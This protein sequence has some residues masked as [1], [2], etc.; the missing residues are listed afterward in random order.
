MR[1]HSQSEA[2]AIFDRLISNNHTGKLNKTPAQAI[3][4]LKMKADYNDGMSR[5]AIVSKYGLSKSAVDQILR[6]A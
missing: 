5:M 3:R 4:N 2:R 6:A 1:I